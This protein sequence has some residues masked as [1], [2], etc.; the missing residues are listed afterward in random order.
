ME[1]VEG[2]VRVGD[3]I[4]GLKHE[5]KRVATAIEKALL[6]KEAPPEDPKEKERAEDDE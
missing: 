1:L 6:V 4:L 3:A 2:V 5:E